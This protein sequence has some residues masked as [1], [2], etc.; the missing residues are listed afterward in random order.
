[1]AGSIGTFSSAV[2]MQSEYQ[3]QIESDQLGE[4]KGT[5][6]Q[7]GKLNI[8]TTEDEDIPVVV[9]NMPTFGDGTFG[10]KRKSIKAED[11][12]KEIEYER[13][14][15]EMFNDDFGEIGNGIKQTS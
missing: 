6:K 9:Q 7:D 10:S 13:D 2:N 5:I 1:M 11:I 12:A 4:L 3:M 15:Q 14:D 8:E